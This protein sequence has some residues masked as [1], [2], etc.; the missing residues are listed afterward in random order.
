MLSFN[1]SGKG[2]AMNQHEQ[3]MLSEATSRK[4]ELDIVDQYFIDELNQK[5]SSYQMPNDELKKLRAIYI[6]LQGGE[7]WGKVN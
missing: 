4:D 7:V 3:T 6:K 5:H 2:Q 1:Q